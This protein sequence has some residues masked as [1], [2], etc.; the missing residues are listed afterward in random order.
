MKTV[1]NLIPVFAW[2]FVGALVMDD[3]KNGKAGISL[4]RVCF[5]GVLSVLF[6]LWFESLSGKEMEL[7]PGIMEVF[8]TLAGYV[9]GTKA[10]RL[11][12]DRMNNTGGGEEYPDSFSDRGD[13]QC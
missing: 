1:W 7:P 11:V 10:V 3:S 2:K 9:F 12:Q 4:G 8:F 13:E 6:V 5:L